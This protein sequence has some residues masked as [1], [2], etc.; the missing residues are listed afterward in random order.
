MKLLTEINLYNDEETFI[1]RVYLVE[2][3]TFHLVQQGANS[4]R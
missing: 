3:T 1:W 2:N 4:E